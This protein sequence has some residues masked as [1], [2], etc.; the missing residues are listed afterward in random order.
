MRAVP[1]LSAAVMLA[2][3]HGPA[4]ADCQCRADGRVFEQ[5]QTVCLA[6]PDGNK[7]VRCDMVLNNSSWKSVQDG[8][9][10]ADAGALAS[11]VALSTSAHPHASH[12]H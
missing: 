8:C 6:Y 5:G 2:A 12:T 10:E 7:L 3:F 9:P 4:F 11:P 1:S